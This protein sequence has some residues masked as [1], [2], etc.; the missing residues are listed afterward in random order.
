MFDIP[1]CELTGMGDRTIPPLPM[2][3]IDTSSMVACN[4]LHIAPSAPSLEFVLE[5][6]MT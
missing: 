5:E 4:A 1:P 2:H 3:T 6:D